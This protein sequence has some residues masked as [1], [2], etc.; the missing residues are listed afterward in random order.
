ME[1]QEKEKKPKGRGCAVNM[2]SILM[3][4]KLLPS[5]HKSDLRQTLILAYIYWCHSFIHLSNMYYS[6]NTIFKKAC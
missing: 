3:S 1:G 2:P 6:T 5:I 4:F